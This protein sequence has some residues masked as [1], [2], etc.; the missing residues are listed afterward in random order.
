MDEVNSVRLLNEGRLRQRR[1]L[2]P[3]EISVRGE[4]ASPS[5][6]AHGQQLEPQP[7]DAILEESSCRATHLLRPQT[8]PAMVVVRTTS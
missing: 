5:G 6:S 7:S 8:V 4:E 3:V 2:F 1:Y